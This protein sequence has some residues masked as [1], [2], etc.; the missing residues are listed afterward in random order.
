MDDA[1][2]VGR[3]VADSAT[4]WDLE[5]R[6]EALV[7]GADGAFHHERPHDALQ[8]LHEAVAMLDTITEPIGVSQ[9]LEIAGFAVTIA[10]LP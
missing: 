10:L 8:L 6:A 5:R 1:P 7:E 9:T 4:R 3:R 2:V